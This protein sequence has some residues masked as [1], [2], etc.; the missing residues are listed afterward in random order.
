MT[1]QIVAALIQQK[2]NGKP[3]GRYLVFDHHKIDRI[4]IPVGKVNEAIGLKL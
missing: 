3:S 2:E 4:T 1:R